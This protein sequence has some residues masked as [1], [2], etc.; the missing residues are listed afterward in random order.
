[1]A[2][3]AFHPY[4][5]LFSFLT[6]WHNLQEERLVDARQSYDSCVAILREGD[7]LSTGDIANASRNAWQP[8]LQSDIIK[9]N[10]RKFVLFVHN[11]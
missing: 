9:R 6:S 10:R 1:M 2:I 4:K 7:F 11:A 8:Q 5:I 3:I